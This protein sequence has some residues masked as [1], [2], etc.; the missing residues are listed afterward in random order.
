MR[1]SPWVAC[2][3]KTQ[4]SGMFSLL[5]FVPRQSDFLDTAEELVLNGVLETVN[6]RALRK[7]LRRRGLSDQEVSVYVY[8][9]PDNRFYQA[10]D[11]VLSN[12]GVERQLSAPRYP[13]PERR[14]SIAHA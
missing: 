1:Q 8:K 11:T 10:R 9:T 2:W 12:L 14:F 5:V 6:P 13:T 3:S 4:P 7:L